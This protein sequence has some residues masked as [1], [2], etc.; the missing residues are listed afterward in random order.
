MFSFCYVLYSNY[1]LTVTWAV[2]PIDR[3][4]LLKTSR[5]NES[6]EKLILY[7]SGSNLN[8]RVHTLKA[9]FVLSF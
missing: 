5:S 8:L 4:M 6:N 9:G 3:D 7:K 1:T 2:D